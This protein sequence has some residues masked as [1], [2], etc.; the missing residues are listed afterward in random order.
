MRDNY[1]Y[2]SVDFDPFLDENP[3][4]KVAHTTAAQK[5]VWLACMIGE[6]PANLSYN[7][8]VSLIL[9]G[10]LNEDAFRR[11]LISIVERHEG[12][13]SC[14]SADGE[15]L[16]IYERFPVELVTQDLSLLE[17]KEQQ[18]AFASFIK[19]EMDR[20]FDLLNGPL[21]RFFLHKLGTQ[22]YCFTLFKHHVI[23][24][25]WSTGVILEDL[26]KLYN[27]NNSGAFVVLPEVSQ[28]STYA[29]EELIYQHSDEYR[30]AEQ[31][32]LNVYRDK[33]P[34]MDLPTDTPRKSP[35]SY[36]SHRMDFSL[37]AQLVDAIKKTGAKSGCSLVNTLLSAFEIFLYKTTGQTTVTVGLPTAG[38]AAT[39][40]L[41]LVGHCVNLLPLKSTV[42]P[43]MTF[44]TY[45][46]D[47]RKAFL[48]AY[49]HQRFSFGELVKKLNIVRDNSRIPLVPVMFNV[50]MGMDNSVRFD[51]LEFTLVSN[52]RTHEAFE[53]FL[54][55]TRSDDELILEWSYNSD[56]FSHQTIQSM[57]ATFEHL[58]EELIDKSEVPFQEIPSLIKQSLPPEW[59][60][61]PRAV[62]YPKD[63]TFVQLFSEISG[64]FGEKEAVRFGGESWNYKDLER[65]SNQLAH[66]LMDRGITKGDI[67]AVA[68]DRSIEMLVTLLGVTK[69]GAAYLPLDPEFPADRIAFM[70]ADAN[71]VL[72]ITNRHHEGKFNAASSVTIDELLTQAAGFSTQYPATEFNG[73]DLAYVLYTSGSTGKPKGVNVSHAS[74]T[75]FLLSMQRE[76]GISPDDRLLAITTIS[77]DIA[78]LELY[79]PLISGATLVIADSHSVRDGFALSQLIEDQQITILQATP[80]SWR[81]LI[82]A[83]EDKVYVLKALC[84]GEAFP[85]DLA[86]K[87]V[88]RCSSV[89]N[90]YGPTET[91]IWSAVNQITRH[92]QDPITIGRP[93]DNTAIYLLDEFQRVVP[94]GSVGEIFIAGDGVANGY[95]H[96]PD[97]TAERFL[98]DPFSTEKGAK[99]YRTGDL[100]KLLPNGE[101]QCLGRIDQQVKIRGYRIE[102]GEI[103]HHLNSLPDIKESVVTAQENEVGEMHLVAYVIPEDA[104]KNDTVSWKDR[105]DNIYDSGVQL[106]SDRPL[107][108]QKIDGSIYRQLHNA[109]ELTLQAKEWLSETVNRVAK[110]RAKQIIEVGSGAGQVL[111]ELAPLVEG[112]IATDYAHTAIENLKEQLMT[113]PQK[114]K[115]V[116][117]QTAPADDYSMVARHSQDLVLINSVAQYFPDTEYM[118]KVVREAVK[119]TKPGGCIFIGDMQGKSSLEMCHAIDQ[120][121]RANDETT[122]ARFKEVVANRVRIE[123]EFVADPAFFYNLPYLIPEITAVDVQLRKGVLLNETTNYHY[124]IWLYIQTDHTVT[125][126]DASYHWEELGTVD[127]IAG[128]LEK[129]PEQPIRIT[130]IPNQRTAEDVALMEALASESPSLRLADIRDRIQHVSH[131]V[132]PD[133]LWELEDRLPYRVHIRWGTDGVDGCFEAVFIPEALENT[134]PGA[135]VG[136]SISAGKL[137]EF[138]REPQKMKPVLLESSQTDAWKTVLR[139]TIPD[140]MVPHRYIALQ[141]FPLTPN[142]KIDR[143]ALPKV[144]SQKHTTPTVG[145]APNTETEK[146]VA[147]IWEDSLGLTDIGLDDNFFDL[148]GHSLIAVKVM[149]RIEKE[150]GKRLPLASLFD[151]PTISKLAR[152]IDGDQKQVKWDCLVPIKIGGTKT[153]LYIVHGAGLNVLL[154]NTLSDHLDE[155]QPIYGLQARGLN[156]EDEPFTSIEEMAAHYISEILTQNPD[157]P[158]ALSGFSLGGIIAYEMARQLLAM[159]KEIKMLAMFDTKTY[160]TDKFL[161]SYIKYPKRLMDISIKVGHSLYLLAKSPKDTFRYKYRRI[162]RM[163]I[164]QYWKVTGKEDEVVGFYGYLNKIDKLNTI[165]LDN[166]ILKPIDVSIHLF[167]ATVHRF[168]IKE[169]KFLGWKKFAKKGVIVYDI[170]GEHNRIFAPPNDRD[171]GRI[172]QKALDEV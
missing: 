150:I 18:G 62:Y 29:T 125:A 141:R 151:N 90:M 61:L 65:A 71:S 133:T 87:L 5:E 21:F 168:Y 72:L 30:Q 45:L 75:N 12:L 164:K 69:S 24:D 2:T 39:G 10:T 22:H 64:K 161:P 120:F 49:D 86:E 36:N 60:D 103:E 166:Y 138:V 119:V 129:K 82:A 102:L 78:G 96:R 132:L 157:G 128:F 135:P 37:P 3:I 100:G 122:L 66:C 154:F 105:W 79:L 131:G 94:S 26:S 170:P 113:D 104:S 163:T 85:V 13:R 108:E 117:T 152:L 109:D 16:I 52:P 106:N 107:E 25:G 137:H 88:E 124:D 83:H 167:R 43:N 156:G 56:L 93:I 44:R 58:L 89:W 165:A 48:D 118:L 145:K 112:Y 92:N 116:S 159:G 77:F 146:Q 1:H 81:M 76:P 54:N 40:H 136:I 27:A 142:N 19:S 171:F 121:H 153:P 46:K 33:V 59:V 32:W 123:D 41:N 23:G 155:D 17:E 99:M 57:M 130:N 9:R 148:G 14:I 140:Y 50:D 20:P 70:I 115:H 6:E 67:V 42:D 169:K 15:S 55:I 127:R 95:L 160:E 28:I 31:Y 80:S 143:N 35:R 97:L 126:S 74:L 34:V 47:R 158:Y 172:L 134:L 4:E 8:S 149:T 51:D 63:K 147:K 144:S 68:V 114:W 139:N 110:L 73:K 84:G 101:I 98:A 111:F 38:Q 11:S 91:T 162:K 7:E 53:L